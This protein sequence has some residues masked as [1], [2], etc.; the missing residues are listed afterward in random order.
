[1]WTG[2]E[3]IVWGGYD[4]NTSNYFNTG[5]KYNPS[6]NRWTATST[7]S[8]PEPRYFH[9]AVW[10]NSEMIVSSGS[11][12]STSNTGGTYNPSMDSWTAT[13]TT[14]APSGRSYHTG[15]WSDSE[16]IVGG[17]F[18]ET[19]G[20]PDTGGDTA[21][22]PVRQRSRSVPRSAKWKIRCVSPGAERLR[23]TLTFTGMVR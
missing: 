19:D 17:G 22:K 20:S 15:V 14:N 9:T 4:T 10:T 11:G 6:T 16:M 3:M 5:G 1:V 2:S 21:R 23:P 12:I 7:T 18:S 13:S 8:A